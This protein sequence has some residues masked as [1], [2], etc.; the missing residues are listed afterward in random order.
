MS[1]TTIDFKTIA[2]ETKWIEVY[3]RQVERG[4][5]PGVSGEFADDYILQ[6]RRRFPV[7]GEAPSYARLGELV[8][9]LVASHR[10]LLGHVPHDAR[11]IIDGIME[12]EAI[13]KTLPGNDS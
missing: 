1:D 8:K 11:G 4:D 2:E 12:V 5:H 6:R 9:T 3:D 7:S 13:L 10:Q